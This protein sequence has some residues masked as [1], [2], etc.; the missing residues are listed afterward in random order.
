MEE[1]DLE[2]TED[3][4]QWD[5]SGEGAGMEDDTIVEDHPEDGED[6]VEDEPWLKKDEPTT[7][8]DRP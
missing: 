3:H 6:I 5:D 2:D 1:E 7:A 8:G 4:S